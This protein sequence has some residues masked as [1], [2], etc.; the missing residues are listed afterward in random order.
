MDDGRGSCDI[1]LLSSAN[2]HL[3]ISRIFPL[4]YPSLAV[5]DD[6]DSSGLDVVAEKMTATPSCDDG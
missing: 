3:V 1:Q 4:F 6:S 2:H 5:H